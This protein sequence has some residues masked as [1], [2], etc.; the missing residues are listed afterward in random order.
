MFRPKVGVRDGS[1]QRLWLVVSL[2]VLITIAGVGLASAKTTV[3]L[4]TYAMGG[5]QAED[6]W[7]MLWP[8]MEANPDIDVAVQIYS[9]GEYNEKLMVQIAAGVPPDLMQVW[10]QYKPKYVEMGI[11]RDITAEWESSRV[12]R[13]ARLYPFV[14]D[15]PKSEGRMYGVPFDFNSMVWF[16]NL[17]YL[18]EKGVV[19]PGND[20]TVEDLRALARKLVDPVKQVYATYN[21]VARGG[22]H[23]LQWTQLWTGHD[24]ISDDR[25]TALVDTPANIEMLEFWND[26]QNNLNATPGWPGAWALSRDFYAGGL[27]MQVGWL[28]YGAAF[29]DR[30]TFDWCFAPM[31]KAPAGQLAFAQGHMFSIPVDAPN[32]EEAWR[33]AEWLIS[34]EGQRVIVRELKCHPLGPYTDLWNEYFQVHTPEKRNYAR[35]FVMRDFYGR[36]LIRTMDYWNTYPE[37]NTIMTEHLGNIFTRQAPVGNEMR[38][39]AVRIQQILD[40]QS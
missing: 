32:P 1:V 10:A 38:N 6:W 18:S 15:A 36:N 12:A 7:N 29:A 40:G 16:V 9:F 33:L 11:L 21:E 17:E 22:T 25:K 14:I 28:S 31:P 13:S 20:W 19:F 34:H 3:Q 35:D 37:V 30:L 26:L 24:W 39:A 27:A 8:F 23:A 2:V 4:A 5:L